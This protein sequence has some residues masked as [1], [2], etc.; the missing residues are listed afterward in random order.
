ME[1]A[2]TKAE[3]GS[4][5]SKS[6]SDTSA[7][8]LGRVTPPKRSYCGRKVVSSRDAYCSR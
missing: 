4:Y 2:S 6:I 5:V 1:Y 8:L 3:F 7:V